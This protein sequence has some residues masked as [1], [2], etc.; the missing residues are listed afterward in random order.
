MVFD[1]IPWFFSLCHTG[2]YN[3][4]SNTLSLPLNKSNRTM[5]DQYYNMTLYPFYLRLIDIWGRLIRARKLLEAEINPIF[6]FGF[7]SKRFFF[8]FNVFNKDY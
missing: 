3:S 8:Y 5:G 6:R 7:F 4:I 2:S 1:D